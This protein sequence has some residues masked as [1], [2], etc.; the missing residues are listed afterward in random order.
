MMRDGVGG[1]GAIFSL[2]FRESGV[3]SGSV[4]HRSRPR[5]ARKVCLF[6][7]WQQLC[8]S[9]G[10]PVEAILAA[11][12][13]PAELAREEHAEMTREEFFRLWN[14][15]HS[16]RSP[17]ELADWILGFFDQTR[18]APILAALC[19]RNLRAG[20]GRV[21]EYKSLL[22]P[23]QMS[24]VP[25]RGGL[26]VVCDWQV[27][28]VP[29]SLYFVELCF[30][31]NLAETGTGRSVVPL[32]AECPGAGSI[33]DS[34]ARELLGVSL[35]PG[36]V[37]KM[38]FAEA[39]LEAEFNSANP[40]TLKILED[41]LQ[42]RL[43]TVSEQWSEKL[44][45]T[46][47]RLLPDQRYRLEDAAGAMACTARNLQR[48]LAAE[49]TSFK[50]VLNDTRRELAIFYLGKVRFSPK[51]VSFMLGYSEPT[52]FYHAF[53]RWTGQTPNVFANS[54]NGEMV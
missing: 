10:Q 26:S 13:L 46:L 17:R 8:S 2:G 7:G 19:S 48:Q 53:R 6:S 51:E 32:K 52:A 28:D 37:M 30:L 3:C 49:G 36:P 5:S 11:A 33:P 23:K 12:S 50:E 38:T 41:G 31:R 40:V 54:Q 9:L 45:F 34:L 22:A 44:K 29:A 21:A 24:L 16:E 4:M 27:D 1:G 25:C 15:L 47:K 43:L 18:P 42:Q 39:D 14:T 20:L 35:D